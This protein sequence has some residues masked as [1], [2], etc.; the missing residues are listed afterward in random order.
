MNCMPRL[1][2]DMGLAIGAHALSRS[3]SIA[4]YST[5]TRPFC[6]S[7]SLTNAVTTPCLRL[8]RCAPRLARERLFATRGETSRVAAIADRV[9]RIGYEIGAGESRT[10]SFDENT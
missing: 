9:R 7:I 8:M 1:L 10:H 2:P 5:F 6:A 3:S 4:R